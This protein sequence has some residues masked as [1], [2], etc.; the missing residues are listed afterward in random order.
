MPPP[1]QRNEKPF[2]ALPT[3]PNRESNTFGHS[4]RGPQLCGNKC[5]E[6][7]VSKN[8]VVGN[9]GYAGATG[10]EA[11][12]AFAQVSDHGFLPL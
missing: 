2:A 4:F 1:A 12:S 3:S 9:D 10:C 5:E 7:S 8:A 6:E 11:L